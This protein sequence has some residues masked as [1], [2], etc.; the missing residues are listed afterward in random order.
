MAGQG[1][2]KSKTIDVDAV[3]GGI[4]EQQA[5]LEALERAFPARGDE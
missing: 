4:A 3:A 5:H 1:R 2:Y